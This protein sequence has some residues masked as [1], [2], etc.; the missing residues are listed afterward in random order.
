MGYNSG[1]LSSWNKIMVLFSL[2]VYSTIYYVSYINRILPKGNNI[3]IRKYTRKETSTLCESRFCTLGN[4]G[5]I[6]EGFYL[7]HCEISNMMDLTAMFLLRLSHTILSES[8]LLLIELTQAY[9]LSPENRL[10]SPPPLLT[11]A[12][13]SCSNSKH[14]SNHKTQCGKLSSLWLRNIL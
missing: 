9:W 13:K 7:S 3:F 6:K 5:L 11:H 2:I 10:H 4:I 1:M 8:I 12:K 14:V